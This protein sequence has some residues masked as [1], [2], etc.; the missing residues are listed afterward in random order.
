MAFSRLGSL[1]PVIE[2]FSK[3]NIAGTLTS[4]LA[5]STP[6]L[7]L[8]FS[9]VECSSVFA[10]LEEWVSNVVEVEILVVLVCAPEASEISGSTIPARAILEFVVLLPVT[11]FCS[12][13]DC[14]LDSIM[15]IGIISLKL[16]RVIF[17]IESV[18]LISIKA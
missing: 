2:Y 12:S 5:D 3:N 17:S 4:L 16:E 15:E 9:L 10:D 1:C 8:F 7:I 13:C 6:S 11:V 18:F 14:N